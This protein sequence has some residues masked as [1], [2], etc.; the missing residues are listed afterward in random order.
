MSH[1]QKIVLKAVGVLVGFKVA[2]A[3]SVVYARKARRDAT[4]RYKAK[5][6]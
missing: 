2:L 5:A 4:A 3:A 1:D 6:V